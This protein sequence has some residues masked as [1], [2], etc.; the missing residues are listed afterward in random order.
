MT[1]GVSNAAIA[2][3]LN[4]SESTVKNHI[5]H[6]LEKTGCESR[7]ALAIQA[8]VSGIVISTE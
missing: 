7:T 4:I 1:T 8:R 6:M 2:K 3:K 5:H